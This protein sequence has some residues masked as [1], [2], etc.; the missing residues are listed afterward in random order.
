MNLPGFTGV[1]SL[2]HTSGHWQ[3]SAHP[4]HARSENSVYLSAMGQDFPGTTC[5]CKGCASG[6]GDLTG[7]CNSVCKDKTVYS[8]G[9]EPY[10]YCKA[11]ARGSQQ[12]WWNFDRVPSA[13]FIGF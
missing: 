2:S 4:S 13:K 10:D 11:A 1:T 3:V 6:G 5:T 12:W 8:K 7:Q 9:S